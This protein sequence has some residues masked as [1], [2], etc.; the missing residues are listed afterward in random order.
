MGS[1]YLPPR[2]LP[3]AIP[4]AR[5]SLLPPRPPLIP[6]FTLAPRWLSAELGREENDA[7]PANLDAFFAE[8]GLSK[9]EVSVVL[10]KPISWR[11]FVLPSM[12]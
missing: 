7:G 9:K 12:H 6:G 4:L 5:V 1:S 3:R 2:G 11:P 8:A 10:E